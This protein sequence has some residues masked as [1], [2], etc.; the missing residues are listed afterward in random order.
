MFRA[1]TTDDHLEQFPVNEQRL[2]EMLIQKG[3]DDKDKN[4]NEQ[5][6]HSWQIA[7]KPP[8]YQ[9]SNFLYNDKIYI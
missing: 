9:T 4:E 5:M 6:F 1:D 8:F 3:T 7:M 2:A